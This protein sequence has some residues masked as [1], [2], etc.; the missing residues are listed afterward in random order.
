MERIWAAEIAV[1]RTL[2]AALIEE[3][4]PALRPVTVEP[5]GAGWDNTVFRVN[6]RFVFRFPRRELAVE[7]LETE[8]RCLPLLAPRLLPI[9]IPVQIYAGRPSSRYPWP[10]AGYGYI[11]GIRASNARIDMACRARLAAALGRF[12]K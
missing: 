5:L 7:L 3:Q 4:C 2:A 9:A 6:E 8:L 1:D 10:F 11:P 12:L